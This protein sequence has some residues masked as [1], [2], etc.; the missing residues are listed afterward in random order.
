MSA[1]DRFDS[2][3]LTHTHTI[4]LCLSVSLSLCLSVSL[5][6][7]LSVSVSLS[8]SLSHTHTHTQ[9]LSLSLCVCVFIFFQR[10]SFLRLQD[11]RDILKGTDQRSC[12][13]NTNLGVSAKFLHLGICKC[14]ISPPKM[15]NKARHKTGEKTIRYIGGQR[16]CD[17]YKM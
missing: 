1:I 14:L 6:L 7:S 15:K 11:V 3:S 17:I 16:K 10:E 4:S 5:C 8:V 12:I 13:V 9:T 2:L